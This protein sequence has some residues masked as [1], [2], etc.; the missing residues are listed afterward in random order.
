[1]ALVNESLLEDLLALGASQHLEAGE[2]LCAQGEASETAFVVIDGSLETVVEADEGVV[3]LGTHAA[4]ALVGEVTALAGGLRSATLRALG[5]TSVSVVSKD[6]LRA[7]FDR[8]P[9]EAARV[10]ATARDRTDRSRVAILLANELGT[11]DQQA[12]AA[13]AEK[14][15]WRHLTDGETLFEAGDAAD[16][17]YLVL[18]GRLNIIAP[19]GE[20][21]AQ[22][23]RGGIVGEFG[24]LDSRT[25]TATVT[26]LRDSVLARLSG[27]DFSQITAGH[28][29]LAMGLVRRIIDRSGQETTAGQQVGRSACIV[30][31]SAVDTDQVMAGM[32][33]PL[34][35]L[36]STA[37]LNPAEI[38][39]LLGATDAS[40]MGV[41]DI[42]HI[43]LAELLHQVDADNDHILLEG[44]I[45]KPKWTNTAIRRA[46]QVIIVCSASPG[47]EEEREIREL[48]DRVPEPTPVWL[49]LVH[50]IGAQRSF[51]AAAL[52]DRFGVDEIHHIFH[53]ADRTADT[54]GSPAVYEPDDLARLGRLAVGKGF[55]LVLSGGGARGFAHIGVLGALEDHG[56]PTDRYIGAS[57]GAIM[58]AGFAE[59]VAR[60]RRED[61]ATERFE[62]LLDYTIPLVAL[63]KGKRIATSVGVQWGDYDIED[64]RYPFVCVA[65]NVT[66][67]D[68]HYFR[69]GR[70]DVAVRASTAIPGVMP[71]V[72]FNGDL[73]VDGGVLDNLPV[74]VVSNDPS[75]GTIVAIDVAPPQGP[76]AKADYGLSVSGWAAVRDR[77]GR[78]K[79]Q[80]PGLGNV[81]MRTM[82]IGSARDRDRALASGT[83]D[84][85][86]DLELK[87]IA[88]LDFD[89]VEQASKL[90]YEGS[91][92]RI[93]QW[94]AEQRRSFSEAQT[95]DE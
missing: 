24:L 57:M 70:T 77:F 29:A 50:A 40:E 85:Y 61:V 73:L 26:A 41:G 86:I 65:T 17:A 69:R 78:G 75:V 7:V 55:A 60:S 91:Y 71:P 42:G 89:T 5:P 8:Y 68:V 92:D 59:G 21:V 44:R 74:D 3:V 45:D 16:A 10:T 1:M 37:L 6:D 15:T 23:G 47:P 4:N 48:L 33:A 67:A 49:A 53:R 12:I 81:L 84:L 35:E 93:G 95:V 64:L 30:A 19:T 72:P 43:R 2:I 79:N 83:V 28:I 18:S 62:N 51:G 39:R 66:T 88:L 38:D 22:I 11:S 32:V 27:A 36:G 90:G 76:R 14:V 20:A 9:D 87:G 56:V 82:L 54:P 94:W 34:P 63:L 31:T 46:D 58:A 13:I 80:Y 52:Q 25:R